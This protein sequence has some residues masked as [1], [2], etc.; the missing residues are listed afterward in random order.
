MGIECNVN[1]APR[2]ISKLQEIYKF[3]GFRTAAVGKA[4]VAPT[5]TILVGEQ[6]PLQVNNCERV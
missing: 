4:V 1:H 3:K 2:I 5:G 6:P